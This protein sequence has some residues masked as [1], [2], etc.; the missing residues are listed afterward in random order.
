MVITDSPI[1]GAYRQPGVMIAAASA[2]WN[3]G[4]HMEAKASIH[5]EEGIETIL[6][7]ISKSTDSELLQKVRVSFCEVVNSR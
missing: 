2:L 4:A 5:R 7:R 1:Q 6:Q 3:L